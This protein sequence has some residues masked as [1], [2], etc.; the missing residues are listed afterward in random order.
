M[1]AFSPSLTIGPC[2][3]APAAGKRGSP[4][5][6]P[7]V[8]TCFAH[9]A[10]NHGQQGCPQSVERILRYP[11]GNVRRIRYP[12]P[13]D[14]TPD[15]EVASD[16]ISLWKQAAQRGATPR[17]PPPMQTPQALPTAAQAPPVPAAPQQQVRCHRCPGMLVSWAG[18]SLPSGD[19]WADP[20]CAC[21]PCG[22][23]GLN[24]FCTLPMRPCRHSHAFLCL[25]QWLCAP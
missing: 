9:T 16:T 22:R 10:S 6:L 21:G 20:G 24:S 3:A 11:D 15:L 13:V 18:G 14:P 23:A 19:W 2:R 5:R 17:Q 12:A 4:R 1:P 25:Q 7:L 8:P